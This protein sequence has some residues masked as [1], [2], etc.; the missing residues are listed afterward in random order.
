MG[1]QYVSLW[2]DSFQTVKASTLFSG[3]NS[4]QL[5]QPH[6]RWHIVTLSAQA[7]DITLALI[8][9]NCQDPVSYCISLAAKGRV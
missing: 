7:T 5:L 4:Q 6:R 3:A 2:Y 8:A 9:R 1:V